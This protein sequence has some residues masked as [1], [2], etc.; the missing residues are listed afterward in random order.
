MT[1]EILQ[2]MLYNGSDVIRDLEWVIFDEVHYINNVE[3]GHV[4]EEVLIMLPAHVNI[5]LLSATVPN[6]AEFADWIGRIKKRKIYVISTTKRPV[7][8][9]H[10]LYTGSGGKTKDDRFLI[11]DCNGTFVKAGYN[12]AL[13]SK[14]DREK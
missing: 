14:K 8:L 3:R 1:T 4:W 5:V 10:F 2:S 9:E 13:A 11:V 7:P 6:T 12:D